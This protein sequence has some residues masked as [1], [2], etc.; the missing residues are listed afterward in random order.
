MSI[1]RGALGICLFIALLFCSCGRG[2]KSESVK[3]IKI[4]ASHQDSESG[5]WYLLVYGAQ[6][7]TMDTLEVSQKGKISYHEVFDLD[8]I[9]L[10]LS[11]NGTPAASSISRP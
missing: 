2:H 9:D 1:Q 3:P 10:F 6:S 5:P 8:R 11:R 7:I 4:V